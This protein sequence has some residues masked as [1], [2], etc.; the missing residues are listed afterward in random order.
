MPRTSSGPLAVAI[1]VGALMFI[2]GLVVAYFVFFSNRGLDDGD[3]GPG[4]NGNDPA[5]PVSPS[6]NT[7]TPGTAGAGDN[8]AQTPA[9]NAT[10]D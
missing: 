6:T 2:I 3:T 1:T 9:A 5:A 8:A 10:P 4:A 7:A